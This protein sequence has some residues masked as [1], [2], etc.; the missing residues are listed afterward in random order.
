MPSVTIVGTPHQLEA[1]LPLRAA[2]GRAGIGATAVAVTEPP[3]PAAIGDLANGADAVLMAYQRARAPRTVIDAPTVTTEDGRVVPI[4]IVPDHAGALD[5]FARAAARVHERGGRGTTSSVAL[6]AQR[7]GRYL[8]LCGRIR[9]LLHEH[10][11]ADDSV[12]WWPADEIIRDDVIVGLSHGLAVAL[13][14][15]HGRPSGWV[16]YAGMRAQHL[17][18]PV[19]PSGIVISLACQ[20]LSRRRIGLSFGEAL[21]SSGAAAATLGAVSATNHVANARWSLRLAAALARAP[22]R[23]VETTGDLLVAAQPD[24]ASPQRYRLV[25]DPM[26]PLRDAPMARSLSRALTDDVV[27][28]PDAQQVTA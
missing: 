8:R 3:P 11:R 7:S 13:Y 12:F 10:G 20:T 2:Y 19:E 1:L 15:G 22:D 28:D 17:L 6:L 26:A 5:R 4:A 9:R 25:G 27:F 16:G 18:D 23:P 24:V 21:V 14:V